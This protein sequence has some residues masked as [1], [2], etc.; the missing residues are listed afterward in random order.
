MDDVV[1]RPVVAGIHPDDLGTVGVLENRLFDEE[2]VALSVERRYVDPGGAVLWTS[3]T[4]RR[5]RG[6]ADTTPVALIMIE[7]ITKRRLAED[8]ARTTE[9]RFRRAAL[10]MS[11]IQDP[12]KVLQ[13]VLESARETVGAGYAVVAS[14]SAD[15]VEMTRREF[16]GFH[17]DQVTLEV[18][19]DMSAVG[20]LAVALGADGPIR[21]RDVRSHPDFHGFPE[22]H[23]VLTSFI[24]VPI[25]H[26]SGARATLYLANKIG[27]E[28]FT[29]G[30]EAI[31]VALATHA[32]VCLE[33][34]RINARSRVLVRDLDRANLELMTANDAKSRFLANVSHELR[35][36]LHAILVAGEMVGDSPVGPL[37]A[38]QIRDLGATVQRSG[39][40][41]VRLIDDLVDLSR[42]E[43]GRLDLRSTLFGLEQLLAEIRPEMAR[44]AAERGIT[45]E[46]PE[47]PGVR[48]FADPVRLRQ[49]LNNLIGNA[50]KFTEPGGRIRVEATSTR[51]AT[52]ITVSDTGIGIAAVDLERAFL[53]FEQVS[54]TAT[55]GAG[56]GLAI[57]RSLA[58]LHGGELA[59]TSTPGAGSTFTL[60]LP[61]G[62]AVA[63]RRAQHAAAAVPVEIAGGGRPVLVVEDDQ[64]AMGLVSMV[65]RLA[66][67]QVWSAISVS[68][69]RERLA[70]STPALVLLD[71]RLGDGS[72]LEVVE[73]M[74]RSQRLRDVPVLVLSADAMPDDRRRATEAGCNDFLAKPASPRMLLAR[75]NELTSLVDRF[76]RNGSDGASP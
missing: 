67:Y 9:E 19:R 10:T 47:P 57:S 74:R 26:E 46:L 16:D 68:E 49:I 75:I 1:G 21:L 53:P 51:T 20:I 58:E 6:L 43:S 40:L 41:M 31:V 3:V 23:P 27:A 65:L 45:L 4:A 18:G 25:P 76:D 38:D 56:L 61:R 70:G 11:A 32:G 54:G 62:V 42:I 59:A 12:K 35:T 66:D 5:L 33:N 52:R 34:A 17:V 48:V 44:R 64:T 63:A 2:E 50:L 71:I 15:G 14:Y 55:S 36:P 29:E 72:G 37:S 30:D 24:A 60:E 39:R 7:D 22:G 13:A 28:E 8:E 69:A 73:E